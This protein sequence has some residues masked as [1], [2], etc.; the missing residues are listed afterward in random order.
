[1]EY[2]QSHQCMALIRTMSGRLLGGRRIFLH[3]ICYREHRQAV[4]SARVSSCPIM[5]RRRE[6]RFAPH[7][8]EAIVPTETVV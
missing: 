1:M 5:G 7:I 2:R 8:R 4:S 3:F 6:K